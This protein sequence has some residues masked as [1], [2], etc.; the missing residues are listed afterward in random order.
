VIRIAPNP[1]R[2][3]KIASDQ[4]FPS[5]FG[6]CRDALHCRFAILHVFPSNRKIDG[7]NYRF[8]FG[9]T[10]C[11][12]RRKKQRTSISGLVQFPEILALPNQ[13]CELLAVH[14]IHGSGSP[15]IARDDREDD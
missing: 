3:A 13:R 5:A 8:S 7:A 4:E 1:R 6:E 10:R 12:M 11:Q 2:N 9:V 14:P 15:E